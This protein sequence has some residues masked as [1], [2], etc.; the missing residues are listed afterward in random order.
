M[1]CTTVEEMMVSVDTLQKIEIDESLK[2]AVKIFIAEN[3]SRERTHILGISDKDG[4]IVGI[5]SIGDI[6]KAMKKL[7]NMYSHKEMKEIGSLSAYGQKEFVSN[8]ENQLKTGVDLKVRD[9]MIMRSPLLHPQDSISTAFDIMLESNLRV[10]PVYDKNSNVV[11][12]I[13]DV[14]LLD[15]IVHFIEN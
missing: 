10:L 1:L 12:I 15:C 13:R 5:L 8:I 11:G 2:N 6:L 9:L 7:M 4:K 3:D 14:D